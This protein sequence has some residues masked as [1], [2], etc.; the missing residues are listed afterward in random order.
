MAVLYE[1]LDVIILNWLSKVPIFIATF[2]LVFFLKSALRAKKA[3][4]LRTGFKR[5]PLKNAGEMAK[6]NPFAIAQKRAAM[7]TEA[8]N[9]DAKDA[10]KKEGAADG[11]RKAAADK[12]PKKVAKKWRKIEWR[13]ESNLEINLFKKE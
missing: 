7:A 9:K 2:P 4:S 3:G 1:R 8:K 6:L 13:T 11:K 10:A 12:K 5:N